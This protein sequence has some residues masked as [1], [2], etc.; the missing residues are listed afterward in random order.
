[1]DKISKF[2][3]LSFVI[4]KCVCVRGGLATDLIGPPCTDRPWSFTTRAAASTAW[5]TNAWAATSTAWAA[6]ISKVDVQLGCDV[7]GWLPEVM[8][9]IQLRKEPKE[10]CLVFCMFLQFKYGATVGFLPCS[11]QTRAQ[12][13]QLSCP[14]VGKTQSVFIHIKR[15]T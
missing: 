13:A 14:D 6:K 10:K 4:L 15:A 8:K 5:A 3:L 7:I 1:M 2:V 12:S 9:I 11:L